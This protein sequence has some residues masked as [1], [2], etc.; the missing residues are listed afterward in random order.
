MKQTNL[1]KISVHELVERF[2]SIAMAQ[3]EALIADETAKYNLLYDQMEAVEQELKS[4][5]GDARHAL[6]DL[7][8]SK[9]TH[10]RLKAALA[11]LA[12]APKAARTMLQEI[13]DSN[14][15][16]QA[17]EARSMMRAL[18]EGRFVPS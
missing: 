13:S 5:Q 10:V 11:T 12:V 15:Y 7:F 3:D 6:L 17:A 18:D 1:D 14:E 8:E 9:N 4:R 16:P 2:V